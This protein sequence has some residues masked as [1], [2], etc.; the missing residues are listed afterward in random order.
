MQ[1][2]RYLAEKYV[3][4]ARAKGFAAEDQ[5]DSPQADSL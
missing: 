5:L 4:S 3:I 2:N 1:A